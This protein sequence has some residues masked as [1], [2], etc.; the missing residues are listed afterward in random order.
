MAM[1]KRKASSKRSKTTKVINLKKLPR[2]GSESA[3]KRALQE[4]SSR[5]IAI[6]V[7]NAPF[8]LQAV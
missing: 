4:A 2:S 3:L 6:I 8:K 1:A 7:L 5:K